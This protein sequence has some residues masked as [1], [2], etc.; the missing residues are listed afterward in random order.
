MPGAS[1][2]DSYLQISTKTNGQLHN[3]ER[4]M[5]F[6]PC[7]KSYSFPWLRK[8]CG[9]YMEN[10]TH[11]IGEVFRNEKECKDKRTGSAYQVQVHGNLS[12]V[13]ERSMFAPWIKHHRVSRWFFQNKLRI[14]RYHIIGYR[15]LQDCSTQE[16]GQLTQ[17]VSCTRISVPILKQCLQKLDELCILDVVLHS[18]AATIYRI[19]R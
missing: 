7:G 9:K 17:Y 2:W 13:T 16:K 5:K 19:L 4:A 10:F 6:Q 3:K 12:L 15:H 1:S 8:Y 11:L 14:D 18:R